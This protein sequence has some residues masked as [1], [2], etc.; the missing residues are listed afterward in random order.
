M[1]KKITVTLP[2]GVAIWPKLN[3]IDVYQPVD[4]KGRPNGAEKRRFITRLEFSDEDHRKVDAYLKRQ[5]AI[6]DL[7]GGKLPWKEEKK[8]GKKTGKLHL[9][10][11]SGEKFP[12]PFVDAQGNEVPRS[13][14]KIG[15][16]SILRLGV[17]VNP[18]TG[19]G[20]GINL[21]INFVQIIEL[22]KSQRAIDVE[23]EQG[24]V[25][26]A[27]DDDID[28]DTDLGDDGAPSAPDTDMDED[29]PF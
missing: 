20:G 17:T 5:L 21:Y 19:F 14:V 25:Y 23:K 27:S 2:K 16:G 6:A 29:I 10:A 15:G 28:D 8:D 13:K 22:K 26:N 18:Y 1:S 11:T 4:K 24:F 12:P 9:E 3:E 7:D